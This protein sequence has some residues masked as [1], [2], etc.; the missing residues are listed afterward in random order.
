MGPEVVIGDP[1]QA[2]LYVPATNKNLLN[3]SYVMDLRW[4]IV[5]RTASVEHGSIEPL[6]KRSGG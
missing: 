6:A 4:P 3:L 2:K 1:F 5:H